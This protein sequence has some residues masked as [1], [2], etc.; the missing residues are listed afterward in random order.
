MINEKVLSDIEKAS[1]A[2][3][4]EES[5]RDVKEL[6]ETLISTYTITENK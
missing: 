1:T 6:L 3:G 5:K 4:L 2:F